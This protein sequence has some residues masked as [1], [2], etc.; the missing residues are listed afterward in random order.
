MNKITGE[1]ELEADFVDAEAVDGLA[2]VGAG[3]VAL[4]SLDRQRKSFAADA[5]AIPQ[6]R[7]PFPVLIVQYFKIILLFEIV[8][9]QNHFHLKLKIKVSSFKHLKVMN[10]IKIV[11]NHNSLN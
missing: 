3:V 10:C 9:N 2:D 4:Q 5:V 1:G 8:F 11:F 7:D 6:L